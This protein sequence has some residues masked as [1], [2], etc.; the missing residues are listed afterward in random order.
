MFWLQLIKLLIMLLLCDDFIYINTQ[1]QEFGST[2][3]YKRISTD[4][5][6]IVNTRSIDITAKFAVGIKESQDKLPTLYWLPNFINDLIKHVSLRIL[7]HVGC[8]TIY[9]KNVFWLHICLVSSMY[10]G[11]R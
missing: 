2:K 5:R 9:W 11:P 3:T 10:V 6:S 4:E 7:V 8:K 1:I